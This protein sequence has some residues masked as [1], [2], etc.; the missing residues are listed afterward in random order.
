M[1]YKR[2]LWS[3]G[4]DY[5]IRCPYCGLTLKYRDRDL[6][7]RAW[8][9]NGFVY[10]PQ[11]RKP[12]RHSEIY[13]VRPDGSPVY[14]TK[15]EAELAILNGYRRAVGMPLLDS[16]PVQAGAAAPAAAA[17]AGIGVMYCPDCGRQYRK[18]ADHF[19]AGCGRKLD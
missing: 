12:L 2:Q 17:P 16:L 14:R 6:G 5:V 18:G 1:S 8:F 11:C 13:A 15:E 3:S 4:F 10:C 19:C 9:P 7:Y